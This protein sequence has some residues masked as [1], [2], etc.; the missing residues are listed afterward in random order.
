MRQIVA[1]TKIHVKSAGEIL[2]T[3]QLHESISIATQL[4]EKSEN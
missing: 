3:T 1:S 4:G 2:C